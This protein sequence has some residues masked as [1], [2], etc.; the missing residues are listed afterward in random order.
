M[1]IYNYSNDDI[2]SLEALDLSDITA[3]EGKLYFLPQ[4]N[5]VFKSFHVNTDEYLEFK[6]NT[7]LSLI[8]QSRKYKSK[9]LCYPN[10]L[11]SISE[12]IC[13]FTMDLVNGENLQRILNNPNISF[14]K[15]KEYLF[16]IGEI[17]IEMQNI[18]KYSK[19]TNFFLNDFHEGN[20][21]IDELTDSPIV[22][23]LD[24]SY[25]GNG[26]IAPAKL[27][28]PFYRL[29][30]INNKYQTIGDNG[31]FGI[32]VIP[33]EDTE[34]Y[35]YSMMVLNFIAGDNIYLLSKPDFNKYLYYLGRLGYDERFLMTMGL[36]YSEGRNINPM[37]YIEDLKEN[38]LSSYKEF[39]KTQHR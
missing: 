19:Q 15:K 33:S 18:R 24:S 13:G 35:C 2:S 17:I 11:V 1:K 29:A 5:E 25:I 6:I 22:V 37:Q 12:Q 7:I 26:L 23:D 8:N 16:K 28:R 27:L 36:L 30:G 39:R 20:I 10:A 21:M 38:P 4:T 31:P 14:D 34:I 32:Q 9:F 3:T